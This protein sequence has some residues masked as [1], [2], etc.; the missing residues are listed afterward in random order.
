MVRIM[1]ALLLTFTFGVMVGHQVAPRTG[2]VMSYSPKPVLVTRL[3]TGPG[4][5]TLAEEVAVDF[6]TANAGAM[7]KL[8]PITA[9]ELHVG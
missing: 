5:E 6:T 3:F 7:A 9:G 1:L 8:L 4:K 2:V